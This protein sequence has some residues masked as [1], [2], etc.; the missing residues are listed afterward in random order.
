MCSSDGF[1]SST[2][3]ACVNIGR[4]QRRLFVPMLLAAAHLQLSKRVSRC[5]TCRCLAGAAS[6]LSVSTLTEY[7]NRR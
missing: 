3:L 5:P 7:I 4:M 6:S 2:A 1:S